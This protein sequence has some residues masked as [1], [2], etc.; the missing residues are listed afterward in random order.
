MANLAGRLS[1]LPRGSGAPVWIGEPVRDAFEGRTVLAACTRLEGF[2]V[3]FFLDDGSSLSFDIRNEQW[4][5]GGALDLAND[6]VSA[7]EFE[8]RLVVVD[9]TGA[10]LRE[11]TDFSGSGAVARTVETNDLNFSDAFGWG[12]V[13]RIALLVT[14]RGGAT[15]TASISFDAGLT[16]TAMT[17][18]SVPDSLTAGDPEVLHWTPPIRHTDRFRLRFAVTNTAGAEGARLH[19]LR[20]TG[21]VADDN[22]SKVN[23]RSFG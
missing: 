21:R 22:Q 3:L 10:V 11:D 17:S 4:T 1:L 18:R 6:V 20:F 16:W 7:V 8:N 14:A 23:A 5:T 9:D 19:A 2:E 13:V 12:E 15:V